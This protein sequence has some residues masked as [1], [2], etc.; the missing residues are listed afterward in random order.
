[1]AEQAVAAGQVTVAVDSMRKESDQA[2]RAMSEQ[3]RAM[4]E[5]SGATA[6]I[7]RQIRLVSAANREHS[8]GAGRLLGQV[9]SVRTVSQRNTEGVRESRGA[10]DAL[11]QHAEALR[12]AITRGAAKNG[13]PRRNGS[14]G[15]A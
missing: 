14:N 15:R 4:K 11:V 5:I 12:A 6:D 7:G 10:T 3:A 13:P 9:R 2:A 8:S 1:M